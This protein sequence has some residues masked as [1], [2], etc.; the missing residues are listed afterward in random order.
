MGN[1]E[2]KDAVAT[3]W[4]IYINLQTYQASVPAPKTKWQQRQ[5]R[6][7]VDDEN[8]NKDKEK[9]SKTNYQENQQKM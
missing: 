5:T 7:T 4:N 6:P 3:L 9:A 1:R 2:L 8:A